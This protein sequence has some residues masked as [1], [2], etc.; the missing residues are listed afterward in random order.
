MRHGLVPILVSAVSLAGCSLIVPG[1]DD[2]TYDLV[3]AGSDVG[4]AASDA[5]VGD[6]AIDG[7]RDAATDATVDGGC[8]ADAMCDD[9]DPCTVDLCVVDVCEDSPS[10]ACPI[11]VTAG[12]DHT[13]APR[14]SGLSA[15]WGLNDRGQLGRRRPPA[16]AD[17]MM[18][19]SQI[20]AMS[21]L[22]TRGAAIRSIVE[23]RSSTSR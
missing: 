22:N 7:G 18:I 21:M 14:R 1:P 13:C 11:E 4:D 16:L 5:G 17:H 20:P 15:G 9:A 6:G 2:F 8:V 19:G 10:D 3:D 12:G 23:S